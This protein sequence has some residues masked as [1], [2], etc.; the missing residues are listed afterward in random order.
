MPNVW[1]VFRPLLSAVLVLAL[2]VPATYAQDDGESSEVVIQGTLEL[3]T[4]VGAIRDAY[5][6]DNPSAQVQIDPGGGL[7]AGFDALCAGDVDIVMSNEPITDLQIQACANAGTDFI[8]TAIAYEAVVF[9]AS[10]AADVQCV[11]QETLNTIWQLGAAEE[12]TWDGDLTSPALTG[13]VSFYGP[14]TNSNTYLLFRRLLPAGDLR[15]DIVTTTE[16]A[17]ILE[18]V[19]EEGSTALAYLSLADLETLDPDGTLAPVA[20]EDDNFECIAPTLS[21]LENRTYPYARTAYLY[22]NADNAQTDATQAFMEFV[23][24]SDAGAAGVAAEQG[25]SVPTPETYDMGWNNI[26]S[27]NVGRTF[28]RPLTP[29]EIPTTEAGTVAVV[30]TSMLGDLSDDVFASFTAR[31]LNADVNTETLGNSAGWEAFCSGTADVLQATRPASDDELALCEENGIAPY[32]LELG[33]EALVFAVPSANDWLECLDAD[34]AAQMFAADTE[35]TPAPAKW[36]EINPDWPESDLLLWCRPVARA[37]PTTCCQLDRRPGL[38]C[39]RDTDPIRRPAVSPQ[40]VANTDRGSPTCCGNGPQDSRGRRAAGAGRWLGAAVWCRAGE[41]E[42]AVPVSYRSLVFS[43]QSLDMPLVRAFLW[44]FFTDEAQ[45][46]LSD[47]A[48]AGFDLAEF[49]DVKRDEV[50]QMLAAY[51]TVTDEGEEPAAEPTEAVE[52]EATE[53]PA[54]EATDEAEAE[55][56]EEPT[57]EPTEEAEATEEPAPEATEEASSE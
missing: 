20:V 39:L 43:E 1:R 28:T 19:Q 31:Y 24:T 29:V 27:G 34:T 8:E 13:P 7:R 21:T 5:L 55:A 56:T 37:R 46:A 10:T 3:E 15:D 30:G 48:F 6:A 16:L 50:F 17:S 41:L 40:G 2:A 45:D 38:S 49:G 47:Y 54:A 18:K 12:V 22:V 51:E 32:R 33:Y 57:A 23:L 4:L 53:E 11:S 36:S 42:V 44:N 9:L 52:A 35:D 26:Q 14:D 25:Y